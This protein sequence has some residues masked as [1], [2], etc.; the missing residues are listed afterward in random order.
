MGI[1]RKIKKCLKLG[2]NNKI[3]TDCCFEQDIVH[4]KK[5]K[6]SV[7]IYL[8]DFQALTK[9]HEGTII[10]VDTRDSSVTP[11]LLLSGEWEMDVTYHWNR[12]IDEINPKCVFD[13][14]ANTGYFGLLAA[15]K[16]RHAQVHFFEANPRLASLIRK[17]TTTNGF[18]DRTSVVNKGVSDRSGEW[19]KL[20]IPADLFGSASFHHELVNNFSQLDFVEKNKINHVNIETLSLGDYI[21]EKK[22]IPDLVK[23][24]VEGFEENVMLGARSL[25]NKDTPQVVFL[26]YTPGAYSNNFIPYLNTLFKKIY[27]IEGFKCRELKDLSEIK[28]RHDWSMLILT[29]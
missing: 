10:F 2:K 21:N 23:I 14:G 19:L 28:K 16:L 13:V 7:S 18:A 24:D 4:P 3:H 26:E 11:H 20:T 25:F 1:G 9:L 12:I 15:G 8:G 27:L 6:E 5:I 22:I 17:S 29:K